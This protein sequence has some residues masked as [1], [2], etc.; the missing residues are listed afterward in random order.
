MKRSS[1]L[2]ALLP[3]PWLAACATAPASVFLVQPEFQLTGYWA[4]ESSLEGSSL[5]LSTPLD[6]VY[7]ARFSS[8]GCVGSELRQV[9]A[10]FLSGYLTLSEPVSEYSGRKYHR[11]ALYEL[12]G[13]LLLVPEPDVPK[14]QVAFA[15]RRSHV[16]TAELKNLGYRRLSAIP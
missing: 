9:T 13:T 14:F 5:L 3:L 7:P 16:G 15:R 11:L 12:G 8:T 4:T 10:R 6:G 1:L 2:A